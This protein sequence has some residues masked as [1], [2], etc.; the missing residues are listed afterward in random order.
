MDGNLLNF[1]LRSANVASVL[2]VLALTQPA[3]AQDLIADGAPSRSLQ[4]VAPQLRLPPVVQPAPVSSPPVELGSIQQVS[5]AIEATPAPSEF[6]SE[7]LAEIERLLTAYG[8]R[9]NSCQNDSQ[10]GYDDGFVMASPSG[11]KI[12]AK[13]VPFAMRINSWFQLRHTLFDSDGPNPDQNDI[14][15]ER[16]RLT[17]GGHA[18]TPD[19]QYYIQLDGD[20]DQDEVIDLLDYYF[21]YDLGHDLFG[22]TNGRLGMQVGKWKLPFNRTRAEAG[23][24][25]EFTD[26]SMA[27][28][29]FDINRSQ[30]VGIFGSLD[31]LG[32]TIN[33]EAAVFNGFQTEGFRPVRSGEL[34][35]NLGCSTRVY[36]DLI[37][38]WGKDGEPDLAGHDHLAMRVGSG[39]AYSRVDIEG[40]REFARQRVVDSGATLASILPAGTTAYDV[41]FYAADMNF[42]YRG[43]SFH[44]EYYFRSINNFAGMP[45]SD[46]FDHGLLLQTGYFLVPETLEVA[47]RWSRISGD[48]GTL[49]ATDQ[50]ADEIAAAIIWYIRGQNAKLTFDATH[51]NGAPIRDLA[52]NIL[53]GDA[54]WL[55]RTQLQLRF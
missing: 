43:L 29:F 24:K 23:W 26:R 4:T 2:L 40:L 20:G 54:G 7:Q 5:H 42:K 6:T 30:G 50:S 53:P 45:V 38:D 44:S 17:F 10:F 32:K 9:P 39:F 47:A 36:T 49:G 52:L 3:S 13:D 51:L 37:G 33:Y 35:R 14:E 31:S 28:V 1:R 55:F 18:Y 25:L 27:S 15:F 19:L 46:L 12:G 48:S 21:T 11:V 41:F 22:W 34:D 8:V 16:V